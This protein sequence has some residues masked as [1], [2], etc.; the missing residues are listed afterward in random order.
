[1]SPTPEI[2]ERRTRQR[3]LEAATAQVA[4]NGFRDG[5]LETVIDETGY[6][7]ERVHIFFQHD[8][9][10]AMAVYLRIAT[11]LERVAANLAEG[12]IAERFH[13][14]VTA[15]LALSAPYKGALRALLSRSLDPRH[16]LGVL[17]Q[18]AEIVRERVLSSFEVAVSGASDRPAQPTPSLAKALYAAHLAIVLLWLKDNT[19][20]QSATRTALQSACAL[21][22][23]TGPA[24]PF[25]EHVP[26]RTR[27]ADILGALSSPKPTDALAERILRCL[28]RH[29]RLLPSTDDCVVEPC[30]VCLALHLTRVKRAVVRGEPIHLLLPAFPAKSPSPD[31][32]LGKLPDGAEVLALLHL[33]A[34]CDEIGCIYEPGARLTIC[35]DGR[36]FSDLVGVSDEDV[37]TYSEGMRD[38]LN[39][40]PVPSI[41]MFNME[42]LYETSDFAVMRRQLAD[43]YAMS[44]VALEERAH[45]QPQAAVLING[46]ERFLR[47]ELAFQED[48]L[49]KTQRRKLC[50]ERAYEV[51][52]RSDAWGQLIT[53]CFPLALRLSIHPQLPHSEKIGILLGDADDIWM[54]PW[55]GVAVQTKRGWTMMKR[56]EAEARG[57]VLNF[58]Q[59]RPSYFTLTDD[60]A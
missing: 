34:V 48:G 24:F 27:I 43:H 11:D 14:L 9:D 8:E 17:G 36:V 20:Q 22:A 40:L 38:L 4:A 45:T 3:L 7:R 10:F 60:D 12:T 13:A 30:D 33:Q 5:L 39:S 53:E 59:D 19:P 47:E 50:R 2:D 54:T 56:R 52:R 44:R 1:M 21:V 6:S 18:Q 51:V 15:K 16:E 32:V 41:D 55:H 31:K 25:L 37:S 46:I 42:D 49:S 28:F 35:S 29:R 58:V 23:R 26:G 57:A